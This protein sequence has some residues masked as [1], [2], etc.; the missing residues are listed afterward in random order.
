MAKAKAAEVTAPAAPK[1]EDKPEAVPFKGWDDVKA[2]VA[3]ILAKREGGT[4]K[5]IAAAG[6]LLARGMP[7][8]ELA[9]GHLFDLAEGANDPVGFV[10]G[11]NQQGSN[12]GY[13]GVFGCD[14]TVRVYR[15]L[16]Y[17]TDLAERDGKPEGGNDFVLVDK[18]T[19]PV[20]T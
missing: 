19:S 12:K 7:D 11:L 18:W 10:W 1:A 5:A 2:R 20:I 13:F 14:S 6:E 8:D 9:A 17:K 15:I 16:K 4:E 3:G